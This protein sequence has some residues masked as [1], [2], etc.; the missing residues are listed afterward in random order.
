MFL[1][2]CESK[3]RTEEVD[4]A[5]TLKEAEYLAREYRIAF[6]EGFRVWVEE[7]D[8]NND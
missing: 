3:G 4:A 6:G 8:D 7:S 2:K 5:E 1:I